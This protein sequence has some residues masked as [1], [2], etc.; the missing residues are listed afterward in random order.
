MFPRSVRTWP[1]L[2]ACALAFACAGGCATTR[3]P[4]GEHKVRALQ[5]QGVDKV[6]EDD[7]RDR[8][9]TTEP[10]W[11]WSVEPFDPNAWQADLRRIERFYESQGYYQARVVDDAVVEVKPGAVDLRVQVVEGEPTHIAEVRIEGLASLPP[12]QQA[13]VVEQFP[14]REGQVFKEGPW[15]D[16]KPLM[17]ARLRELGY[18]EAVVEGGVEVD[19]AT[20]EARVLL[21][22]NPGPRYRFGDIFVATDPNPRVPPKWIIDEARVAIA[23]GQWFSE[24]ALAEAQARVFKMGVF[25]GVRVNR[26]AADPETGT[27]PVVVDVREA[28]FRSL[29]AGG[30]VGLDQTRQEA[31][32]RLEYIDRNFYGGLRTFSSR[33]RVG[34]AFLPTVWD[35]ALQ[36]P[37]VVLRNEPLA[38]VGVEFTQPRVLHPSL[39]YYAA[40]DVEAR[41]EPAFYVLGGQARTGLAWQPHPSL[42]GHLTYNLEAYRFTRGVALLGGNAPELALGCPEPSPGQQ[43]QCLLS[44]IEANLE[45]DRRLRRTPGGLRPD[46]IDP[47]QGY[48]LGLSLQFGG[49][50][51]QGDFT[52][53]RVLPEARYYVSVLEQQ[54]LTFAFRVRGGA[55]ISSQESPIVS[56]FFA[57]GGTS[58]RGFNSRRLSPLLLV[59]PEGTPSVRED[60]I[61]A[62]VG[63]QP[64][65]VIPIGGERL[66]EGSVEA[67]YRLNPDFTWAVFLDT[68]F[69]NRADAVEADLNLQNA[70]AYFRQHLQYAVGTGLRYVTLVGP[71]RVDVAYRLPWGRAPRVYELPGTYLSPS[72]A[73]GCFGIGARPAAFGEN[74]EG[75][76]SLHIS[77]GEAF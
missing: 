56:R 37:N 17:R 49:G 65:D 27:V 1:T 3:V 46:P 8:I 16:A 77:I 5:L 22:V 33:L 43:P 55:L 58:M 67:R 26:G 50:P 41:P 48:Y 45:W 7:L 71:I 23:R 24:S 31:R 32:A 40:L 52:Y 30:G 75:V 12:E 57:G 74:P 76:C 51:L 20:Q 13:A 39:R 66:F 69:N 29:R 70:P 28:P 73:G 34:Y 25:G 59:P 11:P 36:N 38:N 42:L 15:G 21:Q 54:R 6:D 72:R 10:Y 4:K 53:F 61:L 44:F 64:G 19:V 47:A 9:L 60:G 63:R 68:G 14:L 35:V 18:A 62:P 2:L